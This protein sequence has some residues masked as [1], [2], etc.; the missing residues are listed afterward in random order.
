MCCIDMPDSASALLTAM[1]YTNEPPQRTRTRRALLY[2]YH[3]AL[4][5]L[6]RNR[7]V[8]TTKIFMPSMQT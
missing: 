7:G 8:N 4:V 2:A 1:G 6:N 5:P 3:A